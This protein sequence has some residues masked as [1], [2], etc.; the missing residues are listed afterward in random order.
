VRLG[1]IPSV[2]ACEFASSGTWGS[3]ALRDS[4]YSWWLPPPR[5]LGVVEESW[6]ELEIVLGHL[7]V[8]MRGSCA[9]SG[10]APKATLVDCGCH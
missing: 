7:S 9:F 10:G 8:I 5:W 2:F 4:C 6:Q 1:V 3:F